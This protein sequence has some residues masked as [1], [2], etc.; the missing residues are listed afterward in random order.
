MAASFLPLPELLAYPLFLSQDDS[1]NFKPLLSE[2]INEQCLG[3]NNDKIY[4]QNFPFLNLQNMDPNVPAQLFEYDK[5]FEQYGCD[6]TFY[7]YNHPE[8]LPLELKHSFKI[9]VADPP[10]LQLQ[11]H[12]SQYSET[13]WRLRNCAFI[14]FKNEM[15]VS[16]AQ[17]Q[18][19]GVKNW[20]IFNEP[21]VVAALGYDNGF[22][23]PR[24]CS[25]E[26][27]ISS[28]NGSQNASGILN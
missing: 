23:A 3:C 2:E 25:K 14:D 28:Q 7:D 16:Q 10:Y 13:L 1:Y 4:L 11:N 17:R 21:R 26:Y 27:S 19:H 12:I 20:I 24:R 18:L 5:R 22:F 6:Y 8:E 15:L 9:V